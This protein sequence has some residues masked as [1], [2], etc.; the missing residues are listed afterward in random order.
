MSEAIFITSIGRPQLYDTLASLDKSLSTRT[1]VYLSIQD[2]F[3]LDASIY[4]FIDLKIF[5]HKKRGASLGKNLTLK[6]STEK[7]LLFI[8]DD[9][10][11]D[12]NWIQEMLS[13]LDEHDLVFGKTIP[14]Y[15]KSIVG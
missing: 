10:I 4:K 3:Y 2:D 13:S 15:L 5:Y 6:N 9:I 12:K 14:Y 11:V 8:D 1:S 7:K